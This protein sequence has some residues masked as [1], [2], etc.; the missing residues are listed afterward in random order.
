MRLRLP[1][2]SLR[3]VTPPTD[4]VLHPPLLVFP[5]VNDP[6]HLQEE[7]QTNNIF[8]VFTLSILQFNPSSYIHRFYA[9]HILLHSV[10]KR[11]KGL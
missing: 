10:E 4:Q 9:Q 3:S 6:V 7:E 1:G 8:S 5:F 11:G 2:I